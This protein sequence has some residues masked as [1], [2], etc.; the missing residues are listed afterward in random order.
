MTAVS[1]ILLLERENDIYLASEGAATLATQVGFDRYATADI[2]T[3]VS[4]ICSNSLR[5]ADGGWIALRVTGSVLE[6]AVTDRG[7]GFSHPHRPSPGLGIGLDGARRLM[8]DLAI[9]NHADGSTVTMS[10][11]LPNPPEVTANA[12]STWSIVASFRNKRGKASCGDAMATR[13]YSDGRLAVALADGLG[14]GETAASAAQHVLEQLLSAI[15]RSPASALS[16]ADHA[17]RHIRGAAV[18]VA[19]LSENGGGIHAAVGDVSCQISSSDEP[20]L[21]RPGI[22]GAGNGEPIDTYF[23]LPDDA[24]VLF[25]TDGIRFPNRRWIGS[26]PPAGYE[27]EWMEQA[28]LQHGDSSD[29]GA[30]VL[31]RRR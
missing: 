27:T 1:H 18:A 2:E 13:E 20:L 15:D 23:Q 8:D 5:H 26:L 6:V 17:T 16:S 7:P 4:E 12:A 3:A 24:G 21:S 11:Q 14:S 9:V 28:T 30:I 19:A 10:R 29:D 31:V 25:W 22:I